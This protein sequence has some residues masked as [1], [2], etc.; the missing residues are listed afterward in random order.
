[1]PPGFAHGFCALKPDSEVVYKVT[2]FYSREHDLGLA[3]N[4]PMLS[5][6]WPVDPQNAILSDKDGRQPKLKDLPDHFP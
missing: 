6:P 2:E 4:D 5:I 3:W 1:M